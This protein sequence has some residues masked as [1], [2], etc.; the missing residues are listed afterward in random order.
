MDTAAL[1][2]VSPDTASL[3][4]SD[5]AWL[6]NMALPASKRSNDAAALRVAPTL[7]TGRLVFEGDVY[8]CCAV[9]K[10]VLTHAALDCKA[11]WILGADRKFNGTLR[12]MG[13]SVRPGGPFSVAA[14]DS[15]FD[16]RLARIAEEV[17]GDAT[18]IMLVTPPHAMVGAS[19]LKQYGRYVSQTLLSWLPRV[20]VVLWVTH[21]T[22]LA[23]IPASDRYTACSVEEG[24]SALQDMLGYTSVDVGK[25]HVKLSAVPGASILT[26]SVCSAEGA[27]YPFRLNSDGDWTASIPP[28]LGAGAKLVAAGTET[29]VGALFTLYVDGFR[30]E[31]LPWLSKPPDNNSMRLLDNVR[32]LASKVDYS[33]LE[34]MLVRDA[35][36]SHLQSHPRG[37]GFGDAAAS[38]TASMAPFSAPFSR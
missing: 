8:G 31:A 24:V 20:H 37:F 5:G 12:D 16:R 3:T 14:A 38:R 10:D 29:V 27:M 2:T 30:C 22:V 9:F 23:S 19:A 33:S 18:V 26:A 6:V 1:N 35:M 32:Q 4:K 25:V 15:A 34:G 36:L 17:D 13:Y 11:T 28:T 7:E 21:P